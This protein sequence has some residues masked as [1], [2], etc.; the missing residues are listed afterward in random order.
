MGFFV[1]QMTYK[2]LSGTL[3][4]HS[5]LVGLSQV[6]PTVHGDKVSENESSDKL[7]IKEQRITLNLLHYPNFGYRGNGLH[8]NCFQNTG[9]FC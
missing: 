1:L 5:L 6:I 7:R 8:R 2:V 4:L 3:S 9:L